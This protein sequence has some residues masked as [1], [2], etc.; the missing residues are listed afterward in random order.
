MTAD[1]AARAAAR[2]IQGYCAQCKS[3][4]GTIALVDDHD[5]LLAVQPDPA[6]PNHGFCV[7]G[8]AAPQIVHNAGRLRY[9]LRRTTP[10]TESDPGWVRIPWDEALRTTARRLT[11]L[12]ERHGPESVVF[13]RP[14]PGGSHSGDWSQF[15]ARLATAFGSPNV[16]TTSHIC[17]W[18]RGPGSAY[19]YG[20]SLPT[21]HFEAAQTIVIW[22]HNPA[23]S[24]IQSWWRI[25]A[26]QQRGAAL[27]VVDPR[28]T[29]TTA[30]ADLWV[31]P[32]PGT[33]ATLALGV[34][35]LL[36]ARQSYDVDFVTRW[37]NGPMLVDTATGLFLRSGEVGVPGDPDQLLI[38]DEIHGPR[39]VAV[40]RHPSSWAVSP[41]L[42]ADA[43][44]I[45]TD[46]R[47]VRARTA[48][49]LLAERV[50]G[51]DPVTVAER[52]GVPVPALEK[53]AEMVGTTGPVCYDTYNGVEQHIDTA[54]TARALA[55]M[56]A[57]TGWLE[58]AGGN[59]SF[60]RA[61]GGSPSLPGPGTAEPAA[62]A[63]AKRLGYAQRP[64]GAAKQ[65]VQSYNF[66]DAAIDGN[67][68]RAR[69]LIAFGGNALL[70]NGDTRR[71]RQALASLD[72]HVHVDMFENPT[73]RYADLLLPAATA[74]ESPALAT[75]FG[76]GPTTQRYVQ[77]RPPVIAARWE[78]RPDVE[79]IFELAVRLGL[80]DMFWGGD[81]EAAFDDQ[82]RRIGMDPAEVRAHPGGLYR[83]DP[84]PAEPFRA[85]ERIDGNGRATGFPTPTRKV[86]LYSETFV[87]NGHDPLPMGNDRSSVFTEEFPFIL[88]SNKLIQYT[89]SSGRGVP[90]L[91]KQVPQPYLEI[92]P[93][94]ARLLRISDSD[95]VRLLTPL[96]S[97]RLPARLSENVRPG[98]VSTQTGWW[99]T[100]EELGLPGHD[101]FGA[102]GANVNLI[103]ANDVVDPISGSVP[104]KDYPCRIERI[105]P[106]DEGVEV[107]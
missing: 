3:R 44:V 46:G 82:I 90:A 33:D 45:T 92:H 1:Q 11:E 28:A 5:N 9:P 42:S 95:A 37:T 36:L 20:T 62:I 50:A 97:I 76:G 24:H 54:Q 30:R 31:R 47:T 14:A 106:E 17:S 43:E 15:L 86:E 65:S 18:G 101:P 12:A 85:Y 56:Y 80:T 40:E 89:H 23:A 34:I 69:A 57:L 60:A 84:D 2:R 104:L 38:W 88:T 74:W 103:I 75:G 93:D 102:D 51:Y 8:S 21:A 55:I 35:H 63:P 64:L 96:G 58:S 81:P 68:Y 78:S 16:M 94:D 59:V 99:E 100:C 26:A 72:F 32:R 87:I 61:P 10:K 29:G 83:P 13:T 25:R 70:Q 27:V 6:H 52:T 98:V 41:R 48:F 107:L 67:P 66:Y 105:C 4:C 91:R 77:Y 71:G 19:T 39:P 22:G 53:L 7:K 49:S 79:I 73:A